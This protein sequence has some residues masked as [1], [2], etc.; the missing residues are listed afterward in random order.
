[1]T[2]SYHDGKTNQGIGR[3]PRYIGSMNSK[4]IV[5][6]LEDHPL[7]TIKPYYIPRHDENYSPNPNSIEGK[8][9]EPSIWIG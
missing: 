7:N 5:S 9:N 3:P 2:E 4:Q 6:S 1:M 8:V